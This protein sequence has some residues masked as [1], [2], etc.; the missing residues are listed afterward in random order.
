MTF[1]SQATAR[2]MKAGEVSMP[3]ATGPTRQGL[4]SGGLSECPATARSNVHRS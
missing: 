4:G 1:P 3:S 2:S